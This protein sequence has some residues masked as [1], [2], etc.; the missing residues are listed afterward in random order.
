MSVEGETG[1]HGRSA[2]ETNHLN[3][4]K[5]KIK[6][7]TEIED[8]NVGENNVGHEEINMDCA[9]PKAS[10]TVEDAMVDIPDKGIT[11]ITEANRANVRVSEANSQIITATVSRQNYPDWL[12]SAVYASPNARKREEL[13]QTLEQTAQQNDDPW[14]VVGDFNDY[15]SQRISQR[16]ASISS[17]L[18]PQSSPTIP[19]QS[20]SQSANNP[21]LNSLHSFKSPNPPP[22][23]LRFNLTFG[24]PTLNNPNGSPLL[25][26]KLRFR[27]KTRRP[28]GGTESLHRGT[29]LGLSN[30]D[31][32]Q[33]RLSKSTVLSRRPSLHWTKA[34]SRGLTLMLGIRFAF[35]TMKTVEDAN[36]AVEKLNGTQIGG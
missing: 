26:K 28:G 33:A 11:T 24:F 23:S 21:I 17:I 36:A 14:L 20:P 6:G 19:P 9:E 5:K 31:E 34:E 8:D 12:L 1:S 10:N 2:E 25:L 30:N 16:M 27:H 3:R 4:S 35:I 7:S 29:F 32:L 13:W 18:S 22:I 15:S